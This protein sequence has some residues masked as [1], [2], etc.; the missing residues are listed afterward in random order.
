MSVDACGC[1]CL[2]V[3]IRLPGAWRGLHVCGV[4]RAVRRC[5]WRACGESLCP[6]RSLQVTTCVAAIASDLRVRDA[7]R[8]VLHESANRACDPYSRRAES[9]NRLCR[10]GVQA[11]TAKVPL[12]V[13]RDSDKDDD[14]D[15]DNDCDNDCDNGGDNGGR[16]REPFGNSGRDRK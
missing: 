16:R 6:G 8:P 10:G 12:W 9:G 1:R 15:G 11:C 13:C 4:Q 2:A 14:K 7:V 5:A 3:V